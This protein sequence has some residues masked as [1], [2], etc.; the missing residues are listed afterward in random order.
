[1]IWRLIHLFAR[2]AEGIEYL[3][4]KNVQSALDRFKMAVDMQPKCAEA[5]F[6]ASEM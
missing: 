3:Q 1:M 2:L 5:Y 6:R 4:Q